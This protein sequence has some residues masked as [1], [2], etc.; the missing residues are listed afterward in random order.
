MR[1][2]DYLA[3][4]EEAERMA[5]ELMVEADRLRMIKVARSW[6][7]LADHTHWPRPKPAPVPQGDEG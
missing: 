6:R 3:Q 1:A 4:A 2:E 5:E 7:E